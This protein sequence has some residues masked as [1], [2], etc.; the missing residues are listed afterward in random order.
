MTLSDGR[1]QP[2]LYHA[3]DEQPLWDDVVIAA[4]FP[5]DYTTAAL[6]EQLTTVLPGTV[7]T[8]LSLDVL[9]EQNWIDRWNKSLSPKQIGDKIWL[10]PSHHPVPAEAITPIK[11][12]PGL[13]F[14]SGEHPTTLLC[15]SWLDRHLHTHAE[16]LDY[17]CGSGILAIA[18]LKLGASVCYA[19]DNATQAIKASLNNAQANA[20]NPKQMPICLPE[21]LPSISVDI[22]M[23]NIVS[24]VLIDL[25]ETF[26]SLL[27]PS[28]K[29]LL[30]G[31]LT[32]QEEEVIKAYAWHG[33]DVEA[34]QQ[35]GEWALLVMA[36]QKPM[37]KS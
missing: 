20:I 29:I 21:E 36:Q 37:G 16:C 3:P 13:A 1:D 4:I 6:H 19:V 28:G 35:I 23:A 12:D 18:A 9:A 10:C 25:A 32:H 14:G 2:L 8:T 34:S 31:I 11:L 26:K 5:Q 30:S 15:L 7:L 24:G 17:G 33:F 27:R 22:I